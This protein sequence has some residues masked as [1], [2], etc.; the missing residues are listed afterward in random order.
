MSK[1]KKYASSELPKY[2]IYVN[3]FEIGVLVSMIWRSQNKDALENVFKQLMDLVDRFRKQA[4]VK[5][6]Y[7]GKGVVKMTDKS[8]NT[9]IREMYD[10]EKT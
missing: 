6:Q 1:P 3:A 5:V 9:V 4:G 10:W 7:L 2:P 8:G